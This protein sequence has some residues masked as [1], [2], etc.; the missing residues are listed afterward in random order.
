MLRMW[1]VAFL[2]YW[3][4]GMLMR[5]DVGDVGYPGCGMFGI[6]DVGCG[7]FAGMWNVNL[8]NARLQILGTNRI[9]IQMGKS[10]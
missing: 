1:D 4:C 10:W 5:W 7:M 8:Q 9:G 3:G 2:G 6:W